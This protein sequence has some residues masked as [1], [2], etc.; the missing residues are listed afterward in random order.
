MTKS[1]RFPNESDNVKPKI[2]FVFCKIQRVSLLI[3][4]LKDF[5]QL[6]IGVQTIYNSTM[7]VAKEV[8]VILLASIRVVHHRLKITAASKPWC[9]SR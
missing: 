1:S 7:N 2:Y 5:L 9:P 3:L 4:N 6:L 8:D